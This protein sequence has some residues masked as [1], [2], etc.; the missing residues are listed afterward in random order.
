[1]AAVSVA[2]GAVVWN[3]PRLPQDATERARVTVEAK[4]ALLRRLVASGVV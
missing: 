2:V 4:Q 1:M 3:N